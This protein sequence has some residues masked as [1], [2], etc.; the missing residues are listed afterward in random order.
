VAGDPVA[1]AVEV[2]PER[3]TAAIGTA[4]LRRDGKL[5]VE[6]VHHGYGTDWVPGRV[7][8]LAHRW[9]PCAVVMD[10]GS[11]A[12]ALVEPVEQ[13]GV[14]VVR[15]FTARDAAAAC[16]QFY[17]GVTQA[18]L[19]WRPGDHGGALTAAVAGAKTRR[20]GDAWA[21]DRVN[22]VVDISPLTAVTLAG[23]G[24]NR[25]GRSKQAPYDLLRSVR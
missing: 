7:A 20:L 16:S 14:A 24:F 25:F 10:P 4:G 1:F 17:D 21:W 6:V 23:W 8:E 15:P 18:E 11:H 22:A 12:G 3:R 5:H 2:G 19:R 9:R 13:L